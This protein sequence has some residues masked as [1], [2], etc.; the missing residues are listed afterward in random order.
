ML[1]LLL[2]VHVVV[3]LQNLFCV[4]VSDNITYFPILLLFVSLH[5]HVLIASQDGGLT[6]LVPHL[7][8]KHKDWKDSR[9]EFYG[10]SKGDGNQ[11][12][13]VKMQASQARL[14]HLLRK[15]RIPGDLTV[16]EASL[17]E[18]PAL[19]TLKHYNTTATNCNFDP[20]LPEGWD[21]KDGFAKELQPNQVSR[22]LRLSELVAQFSGSATSPASLAFVMLPIPKEGTPAK[23]YCSLLDALS[24]SCQC[25]TIFIRGNH[26][27][28]LT[29]YS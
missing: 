12:A 29:L 1:L 27:D 4:N 28:V 7:I 20:M 17:K 9:I 19:T 5:C 25:P 15:I 23:Q 24:A 22:M 21:G 13:T 18:M 14:S 26:T 8:R 2:F 10:L 11:G 16:C 3:C 6:A